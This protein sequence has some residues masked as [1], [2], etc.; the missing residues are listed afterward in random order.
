MAGASGVPSGNVTGT[1]TGTAAS[2]GVGTIVVTIVV[3][4][5]VGGSA[6]APTARMLASSGSTNASVAASGACT[7]TMYV[8]VTSA[9]ALATIVWN[10]ACPDA[11]HWRHV[12]WRPVNVPS[13]YG[14]VVDAEH[15]A[16]R[17]RRSIHA[18]TSAV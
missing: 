17:S 4:V 6:V 15:A 1:V 3:V 10:A 9:P 16:D 18:C 11:P 12:R 7:C 8:R 5:T 13:S 2:G 14:S